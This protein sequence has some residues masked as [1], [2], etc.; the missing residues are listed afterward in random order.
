[1]RNKPNRLLD[2]PDLRATEQPFTAQ[3][4]HAVSSTRQRATG[5]WNSSLHHQKPLQ[6]NECPH[7]TLAERD[8]TRERSENNPAQRLNSYLRLAQLD[9]R[10]HRIP[11]SP[12]LADPTI[13]SGEHVF[14]L[15]ATGGLF[16]RSSATKST[17][18]REWGVSVRGSEME[19]WM[20]GGEQG[21]KI[22]G[23]GK[24]LEQTQA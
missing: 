3:K 7:N 24:G 13:I 9:G 12:P 21:L 22:G 8:G 14:Q 5:P 15:R 2:F 6:Q 19:R 23:K 17:W 1:M 11:H 18:K 16:H 10:K 4:E 20:D